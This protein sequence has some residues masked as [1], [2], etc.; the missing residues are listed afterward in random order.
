MPENAE[1]S[2]CHNKVCFGHIKITFSPFYFLE[3]GESILEQELHE[4][5]NFKISIRRDD[6][7]YALKT[8]HNVKKQTSHSS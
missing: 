1:T 7:L 3:H 8:L 6:I 4:N 5:F 2:M